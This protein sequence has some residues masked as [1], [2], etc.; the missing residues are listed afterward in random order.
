M[1]PI[2]QWCDKEQISLDKTR[3]FR[4]T[5]SAE[6]DDDEDELAEIVGHHKLDRC[7]SLSEDYFPVRR[8]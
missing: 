4:H 1:L 5:W 7:T 8:R 3:S 6:V 2:G